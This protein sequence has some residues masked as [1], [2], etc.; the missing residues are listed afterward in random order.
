LP[1]V[2]TAVNGM[3]TI[4]FSTNSSNTDLGW[5]AYFSVITGVEEDLNKGLEIYPNPADTKLQIKSSKTMNIST[6]KVYNMLGTLVMSELNLPEGITS[7]NT[8]GLSNGVYI[9]ELSNSNSI[10][11]KKILIKH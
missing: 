3:M 7:I 5:D 11:T 1:P 4:V 9:L 2:I 10:F 8:A 6:V